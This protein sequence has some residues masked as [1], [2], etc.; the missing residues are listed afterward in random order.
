MVIDMTKRG[1]LMKGLWEILLIFKVITRSTKSLIHYILCGV[2][3]KML[4][5]VWKDAGSTLFSVLGAHWVT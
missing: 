4:D 2:E 5:E 3:V 1:V